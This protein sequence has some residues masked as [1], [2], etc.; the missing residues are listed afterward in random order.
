[1]FDNSSNEDTLLHRLIEV[2]TFGLDDLEL[3]REGR[4]SGLQRSRLALIAVFYSI[5]GSL[6]C[7]LAIGTTWLL[8]M[9]W[10]SVPIVIL[11]LGIIFFVYSA[12]Y[13][14][15][16]ALPMWQDVRT[17]TVVR[18]SGPMHQIYTPMGG[19]AP[20][21]A[22]HY[23]IARKIFDIALFAHQLIPQNQ[24]CHAYYTPRSE[25]LVGIEPV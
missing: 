16:H 19:K 8:F 21:Y 7:T 20:T 12:F 9:Q 25:V 14:L 11:L 2:S 23:R 10:Q 1:M 5:A 4:M 22:L 3:N 13:W 17:G 15:R 24:K 6:A 18:V